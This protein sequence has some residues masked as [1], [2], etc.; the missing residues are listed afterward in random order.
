MFYLFTNY[1]IYTC[2]TLI[3]P[4]KTA[5]KQNTEPKTSAYGKNKREYGFFITLTDKFISF[6][7]TYND[8]N[9]NANGMNKY[10]ILYLNTSSK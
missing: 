2:K 3:I 7:K 5:E 8:D 4:S 6:I 1:L 9:I 10:L